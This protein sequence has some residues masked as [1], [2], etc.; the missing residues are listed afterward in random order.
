MN[1]SAIRMGALLSMLGCG[2]VQAVFEFRSPQPLRD[3]PIHYR[4]QP[5]RDAYWYD[6]VNQD[7][8]PSERGLSMKNRTLY[9]EDCCKPRMCFSDGTWET[10]VWT[11]AYYRAADRAFFDDKLDCDGEPKN[12]NTRHTTGLSQLFFGIDQATTSFVAA[13][14]FANSTIS[15]ALLAQTT[16]ALAWSKITPN[17]KFSEAGAMFGVDARRWFGKNNAWYCGTRCSLPFVVVEVKPCPVCPGEFEE[18]LEDV[19]RMH[20]LNQDLDGDPD[21][22]E[23]T[24]RLDFLSSLLWN[25][26]DQD[27]QQVPVPFLQYGNGN[28]QQTYIGTHRLSFAT[29]N[30]AEEQPP[31]YVQRRLDGTAPSIPYRKLAS[32]VSGALAADGSGGGEN[33]VLFFEQNT[34]YLAGV[35]QDIAAQSELWLV[36]R[37]NDASQGA[38]V[39]DQLVN[40]AQAICNEIKTLVDMSGIPTQEGAVEFL[41]RECDINLCAADRVVG[42]GDLETDLYLGY[43][44]GWRS[45]YLD[46]ITGVLWPTGKKQENSGDVYFLSTGY[47]GHFRAKIGMEGGWMPCKWFAFKSDWAFY[48]VFSRTEKRAAPFKGATIR[49]VGPQINAKVKWNYW[50]FHTDFTFFHPNNPELGVVLSYELF[51]RQKDHVRLGCPDLDCNGGFTTDCLGQRQELDFTLYET[52][53]NS[54]TNK[55]RGEVFNRSDYFELFVGASQIVGGRNAMQ[56]TEAHIG[57]ALYF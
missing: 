30:V 6:V 4:L 51:A 47:N 55:I 35:G 17:L 53:T 54:M 44:K 28:D 25:Y 1:K 32:Q 49:N 41:A 7:A 26:Q 24:Y 9:N 33:A 43:G 40:A 15:P 22:T 38:N 5:V 42:L 56:E 46:A 27:G 3:G 14:S 39:P 21:Q 8:E 10:Y 12:N 36:P 20:P 19:C 16:T 18:T 57:V 34:N 13:Q 52:R 48:H 29:P 2:I 50:I 11:G 37:Q 31:A 45:W 23:C